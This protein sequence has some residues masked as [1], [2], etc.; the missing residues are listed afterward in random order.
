MANFSFGSL[1]T[2]V[3]RVQTQQPQ[4]QQPQQQQQPTGK[5][6]SSLEVPGSPQQ[7]QQPGQQQPAPQNSPLDAFKEMWQT[8]PENQAQNADPFASPLFNME[9]GKVDEAINQIDFVK[10]MDPALVQRAMSGQDPQAFMELINGTARKALATAVQLST[11][12]AEQ[13]GQKIGQ[14]FNTALP[15]RFKDLQ[16]QSLAPTN[17][18]LSNPAAAPMLDAVR[19]R[20][21]VQNPDWTPAQISQKAEDYFSAFAQEL[22]NS[23]PAKA[24]E[25]KQ[26]AAA[27]QE[28][29]WDQ[30]AASTPP[31]NF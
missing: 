27:T 20:L 1:F 26:Q 19:Q 9:P 28:T 25:R 5:P 14:R 31:S 4:Q 7:Q 10:Q 13:A 30:W 29:D 24:A 15:A 18:L 8:T 22:Q 3:P 17:P 2:N 12:T 6:N 23:D 11:A 16:I 21:K